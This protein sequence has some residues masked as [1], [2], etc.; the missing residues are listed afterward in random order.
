VGQPRDGLPTASFAILDPEARRVTWHRTRYDI[1]AVQVAMRKA[2]LP[3]FLA[4]R[5]E[6]GA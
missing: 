4:R 2:G 1:G 3:G 6:I 5:L